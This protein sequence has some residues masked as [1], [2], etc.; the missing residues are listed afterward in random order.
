MQLLLM[1][2]EP[3]PAGNILSLS[4]RSIFTDLSSRGVAARGAR[5]I[6]ATPSRTTAGS[7]LRNIVNTPSNRDDIDRFR[8]VAHEA[9]RIP[10]RCVGLRDTVAI[11]AAD[12]QTVL[13][14]RGQ[15]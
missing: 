2:S 15:R 4:G 14:G 1:A 8:D 9:G 7:R 5:G 11:G 3:G 13:T 6:D 12:Q 10:I